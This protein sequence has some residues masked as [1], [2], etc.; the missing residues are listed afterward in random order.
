MY[1]SNSGPSASCGLGAVLQR[2]V[3]G[4]THSSDNTSIRVQVHWLSERDLGKEQQLLLHIC[5]PGS[6][7]GYLCHSSVWVYW[8]DLNR[9]GE[10]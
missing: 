3:Q 1:P 7:L 2:K 4:C 6:K 9:K 8:D 10:R 5:P